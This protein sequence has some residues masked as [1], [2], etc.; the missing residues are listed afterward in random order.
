MSKKH[1]KILEAFFHSEISNQPQA[2]L[3]SNYNKDGKIES[4]SVISLACDIYTHKDKS[5]PIDGYIK[6]SYN[7][8]MSKLTRSVTMNNA[9]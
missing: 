9:I 7:D 6:L 2:A 5:T 8:M 4:Y 1:L 3:Q